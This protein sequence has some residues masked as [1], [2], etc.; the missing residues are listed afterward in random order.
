MMSRVWRQGIIGWI[1][2]LAIFAT[3][4]PAASQSCIPPPEGLVSWWAAEGDAIDSLGSNHGMMWNGANFTD[5]VTGRAFSFDGINDYVEV[6]D[7]AG[8]NLTSALTIEAWMNPR[9]LS[10]RYPAIVK[11]SGLRGG[12]STSRGYSLE[13]QDRT[14]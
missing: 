12:S 1:I 2:V 3:G 6:P 13:F 11:K 4:K 8:L 14:P 9:S 5:G 7:A 10:T